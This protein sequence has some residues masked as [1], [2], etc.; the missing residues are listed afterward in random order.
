MTVYAEIGVTS[1]F[2]FLR[3][4]SHPQEYVQRASKYGLYAIGIADC[5]TLAG[6][7]R[8]YSE[9]GNRKRV[10]Y[11]P[12]LLVGARLV[13]IDDTPDI[14]AYPRDRAAY[15]RLCQLLSKGKLAA[16]KGECHLRFADLAEFCEGLLLVVM[17]DYRIRT[18][19]TLTTLDA[20]SRCPIEG[21]WLAATLHHR[22]DDTR[23]MARLERIATT[24]RVPLIATSDVLYHV[25]QRRPLQDVLC[26]IREKATITTAGRRLQAHAERHLRTPRDMMRLFRPWPDAL[27]ETI[28]FADRISFTLD[29]L[30]YQYPDEPVPPGKS[31]QQHLEDL[32]SAGVKKYFPQ[33]IDDKLRATL[34]K[35]LALIAELDYAHYFL[36]VHDIVRWAKDRISCVRGAARRPI[37][38]FVMSSASPRSIRP[39]STFCSGASSRRSGWSRRIS[40][41]ISSTPAARR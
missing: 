26:C 9:Y 5:N 6:V 37:P 27:A 23:R 21:A 7:V 18:R 33:G 3:G 36:T 15:G 25:H 30:K 13:F 4:A 24:A 20:L 19:I 35:E 38:R 17:P 28:R 22:G 39:R 34:R 31:A 16:E 12:K 10:R 8:A 2:S 41:S 14:L 11:K 32:T 1:N 29:Q 40:T